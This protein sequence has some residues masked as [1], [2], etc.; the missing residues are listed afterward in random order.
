MRG[1]SLL[2][3]ISTWLVIAPVALFFAAV[4]VFGLLQACRVVSEDRAK[5]ILNVFVNLMFGGIAIGV[6]LGLLTGDG[7]SG[8]GRYMD[9]MYDP[10]ERY[11]Y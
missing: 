6:A 3:Q 2:E 10:A 9:D 7:C 8:G 4:L 11:P 1:M 5:R